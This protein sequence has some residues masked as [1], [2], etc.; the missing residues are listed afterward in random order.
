MKKQF[1]GLFEYKGVEYDYTAVVYSG[2]DAYV[3]P[4]QITDLDRADG[5]PLDD[6]TWEEAE[7][8]ALKNA[9]LVEWCEREGWEEEDTGGGCFALTKNGRDGTITRITR[10]NDPSVPQIMGEPV[11]IGRYDQNDQLLGEIQF[12][13]GGINGWLSEQYE[14]GNSAYADSIR[15]VAARFGRGNVNPRW[16]EAFMRLEY[17]SLNGVSSERFEKEIKIAIGCIDALGPKKAEQC[18]KSFGL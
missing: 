12:F 17:P 8:I 3:Y 13:K 14:Q 18:A 1:F 7:F 2:D 16:V 15:E 4:D 9:Y 5:E 10:A 11:S 6:D